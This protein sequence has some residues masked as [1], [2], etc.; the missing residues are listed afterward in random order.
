MIDLYGMCSPNVTKVTIMLEELGLPYRTHHV[1]VA[2]GEQFAPEFLRLNPNNK[3]PVIVDGE[4]PDGRPFTVFESGAI[5]LYLAAKTGRLLP[6]APA[7]RS[8]VE[9]WLMVQIASIGPMFGQYSHFIRFAPPGNDYGRGRYESET[10]RLFKVLEVRLAVAPFL[11]GADYSIADVATFP[12]IRTARAFFP[13]LQSDDVP[14]R[15]PALERWLTEIGTRPAVQRGL[16]VEQHFVALDL[17]SFGKADAEAVDRF[18]GRGRFA[19]P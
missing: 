14:A 15:Y 18:C 13:W 7:A 2:T 8:T 3:V 9:Q 1:N 11:G 6:A 19:Q 5:L 12:W 16:E 4:G 17:E 10:K